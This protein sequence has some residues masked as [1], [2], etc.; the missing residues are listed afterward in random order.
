MITYQLTESIGILSRTPFV[1]ES[2]LQDIAIAWAFNNEGK[3]TFSP[4]D[5]VGH[6]IHGEKTDWVAR[7][8]IILSDKPDKTFETYD[9]FAQFKDSEGK[10][11]NQLLVEFKTL[12]EKNLGILKSKNLQENDLLKT[13]IHPSFGAVTLQQLLSTWTVHDL[14]HIAQIT[15][16]MSK[17]YKEEVGPWINY[18]PILTR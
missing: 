18:L 10:T 2:L 6:L 8:E 14:S 16:V 11:L 15:R 3:D 17:Q 12:R 7:M 13:G 4:F 9:R 1:L 5:V